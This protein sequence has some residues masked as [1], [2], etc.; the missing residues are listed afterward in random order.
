M[1]DLDWEQPE[2]SAWH[3]RAQTR[4]TVIPGQ[5]ERL[6]IKQGINCAENDHLERKEIQ[7]RD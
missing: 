5:N 2:R 1:T 7:R 3:K 4:G 6:D